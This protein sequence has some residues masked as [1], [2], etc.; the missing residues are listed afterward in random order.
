MTITR[1]QIM[2][3]SACNVKVSVL[4]TLLCYTNSCNAESNETIINIVLNEVFHLSY[5]FHSVSEWFTACMQLTKRVVRNKCLVTDCHMTLVMQ[6]NK[7]LSLV[8]VRE[9]QNIIAH[10]CTYK[11]Q[12]SIFAHA[13]DA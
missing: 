11:I 2:T 10:N 9:F 5:V 6:V 1:K 7:T 3:R 13:I 12:F 8:S 4:K